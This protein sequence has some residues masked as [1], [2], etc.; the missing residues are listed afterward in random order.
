MYLLIGPPS[1]APS[2]SPTVSSMPSTSTTNPIQSKPKEPP[3]KEPH[4]TSLFGQGT[5]DNFF[6]TIKTGSGKLKQPGSIVFHFTEPIPKGEGGPSNCWGFGCASEGGNNG[7]GH[8]KGSGVGV[9]KGS[10]SN[11]GL[12]NGGNG[13]KGGS[14]TSGTS[15][16]SK[17]SKSI[18]PNGNG[19]T[20]VVSSK[21]SKGVKPTSGNDG[22][23]T[24]IFITGKSNMTSAAPTKSV[25]SQ[26][27]SLPPQPQFII[28]KDPK[29]A[30]IEPANGLDTVYITTE[31]VPKGGDRVRRRAAEIGDKDD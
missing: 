23:F 21:A 4:R 15:S 31:L 22:I 25:K 11:N 8:S 12:G 28:V 6:S 18:L 27:Q 5:G 20:S 24:N 29:A 30:P 3:L 17:G 16:K 10:S 14:K 2:N 26:G 19:G 7:V 9:T 13:T 1:V